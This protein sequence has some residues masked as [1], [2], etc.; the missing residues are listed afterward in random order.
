MMCSY[1]CIISLIFIWVTLSAQSVATHA[2]NLVND[3]DVRPN[4][5]T[6][7]VLVGART[8]FSSR[9][10]FKKK[11]KKK[12]LNKKFKKKLKKKCKK[13][14]KN[15]KKYYFRNIKNPV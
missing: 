3:N 8:T 14:I 12:K 7:M 1:T 5:L 9:T 15:K 11:K 4:K 10:N 6:L 2:V 13:K